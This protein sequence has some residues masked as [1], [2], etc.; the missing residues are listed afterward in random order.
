MTPWQ[1]GDLQLQPAPGPLPECGGA[2][3]PFPTPTALPGR[4]LGVFVHRSGTGG[5]S[6]RGVLGV[7]PNALI[8]LPCI[9]ESHS[10]AVV[11]SVRVFAMCFSRIVRYFLSEIHRNVI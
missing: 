5:S 2:A 10:R 4:L 11:L 3:P 6:D 8:Y 1:P 7:C 9:L